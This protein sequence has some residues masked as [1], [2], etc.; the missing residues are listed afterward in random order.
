VYVNYNFPCKAAYQIL[1]QLPRRHVVDTCTQINKINELS[2]RHVA[3]P[4]SVSLCFH[5]IIIIIIIMSVD[6]FFISCYVS[7][8]F[9]IRSV[10]M[11]YEYS[12][13]F[14]RRSLLPVLNHF[15]ISYQVT[16]VFHIR[17]LLPI[18]YFT[19]CFFCL[20]L[21]CLYSCPFVKSLLPVLS[22]K[23]SF[24]Y[25]ICLF[26]LCISGLFCFCDRSLL[27]VYTSSLSCCHIRSLL[28]IC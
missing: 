11:R 1:D 3:D 20:G 6:H 27:S 18:Y 15:R 8:V 13:V 10:S 16:F 22:C 12:F 24:A 4:G 23:V 14:H 26:C 19:F 17:S 25:M 2:R 7:F 21:F 5:I 9:H 28:P